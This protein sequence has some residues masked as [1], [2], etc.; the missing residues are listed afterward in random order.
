MKIQFLMAA[1]LMLLTSLIFGQ[2]TIESNVL[3]LNRYV[4]F[5][6]NSG[7]PL[8]IENRGFD[9][10]DISTN[11]RSKFAITEQPVWNGLNGLTRNNVQ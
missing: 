10:I 6:M 5:D 8:P 7:I 4:G 2:V 11:G 1:S 9:E 3:A